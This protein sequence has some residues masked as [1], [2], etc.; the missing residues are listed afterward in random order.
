[1]KIRPKIQKFEGGK[2]LWYERYIG[3]DYDPSLYEYDFDPS[4]LVAIDGNTYNI[5]APWASTT[6]GQD[7][8]R[9]TPTSGHG[10]FGQGGSHFKYT[11][12]IEELP[13]YEIFG[14][15]LID[16]TTGNFTPLGEAWA[17][18]VDALLPPNHPAKFF[19]ENQKLRTSWTVHTNDSHNRLPRTYSNLKDYV[20]YIRNDQILGARHNVFL[21]K[22]KRYF[23]K[24][25]DGKEHWVDPKQLDGMNVSAKPV[26]TSW[27][28]DHTVFWEDY[29]LTRHE[30]EEADA[31]C[32]GNWIEIQKLYE[33]IEKL[34]SILEE[35]NIDYPE[36]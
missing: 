20:N 31:L 28:D 12:R 7:R 17:K 21:N 3:K 1:M 14:R 26:R 36:M 34:K 35:N 13:Y 15:N 30:L 32:H 25:E 22:G 2:N 8:G 10:S 27:N 16:E 5:L 11:K 9:Y 4:E 33:Y 6:A 23:Y 24:D 29:E 19:D 18:A